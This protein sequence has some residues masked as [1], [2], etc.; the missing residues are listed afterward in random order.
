MRSGWSSGSIFWVLLV[1]G[2]IS[3]SKTIIPDAQE[4]FLTPSA[5]RNAHLFGG[6]G[7]RQADK[8][9]PFEGAKA[10]TYTYSKRFCH[11]GI[12]RAVLVGVPERELLP[13]PGGCLGKG[14]ILAKTQECRR[15]HSALGNLS[16][17]EFAALAEIAY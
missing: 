8:V 14:R 7:V 11:G 13:V 17:R 9:A 2:W 1:S 10:G 4:H 16:P 3:L 6:L 5:R 12:Q 15:L